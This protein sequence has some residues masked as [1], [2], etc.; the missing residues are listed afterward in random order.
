MGLISLALNSTT[1]A[2]PRLDLDS[3]VQRVNGNI[4]PKPPEPIGNA[5]QRLVEFIPIE[6]ITLFWLAVPACEALYRY[7]QSIP[8]EQNIQRPTA[9][10]WCLY[11]GMLVFTPVLLLLVYLSAKAAQGDGFP[12]LRK[13]PWWRAL[14]STIAFAVWALAVPGNPYIDDRQLLMGVWVGA[15]LVSLLLSLFD[16]IVLKWIFPQ[17]DKPK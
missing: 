4:A 16:P 17:Q 2:Q 10:D 7:S 1:A 5:L 9:W 14:A 12:S 8:P 13:W 15:F 11:I 3:N 6:S